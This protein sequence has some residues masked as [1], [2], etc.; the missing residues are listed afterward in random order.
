VEIYNSNGLDHQGNNN[1]KKLWELGGCVTM[2][3][4]GLENGTW[5]LWYALIRLPFEYHR[6]HIPILIALSDETNEMYCN[7]FS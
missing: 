3:S 4:H 6:V 1:D 2:F 7:V 5:I